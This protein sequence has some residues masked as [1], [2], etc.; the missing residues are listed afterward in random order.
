MLKGRRQAAIQG[1]FGALDSCK[2]LDYVQPWLSGMGLI[3]MFHRVVEPGAQV[4]DPTLA[5]DTESLDRILR[6]IRAR[7][8][9]LITVDELSERLING[10]KTRPFVCCTF[11]DGY[12]DNKTLALPIFRRYS[13]PFCVNVTVG[14]VNRTA[15]AWWDALGVMLQTQDEIKF[16]DFGKI[17]RLKVATWDEKLAAYRQFRVI[18]HREVDQGRI[19]F[20]ESWELNGI[21]LA[22]STD[23]LFMSW[24]ELE[25]LAKDPL[26]RI[27]SHTLTHPCLPHLSENEAG[28]EIERSKQ[29]LEERLG[30]QVAHLAYPFGKCGQREFRLVKELRFKTAVTSKWCNV[31]PAHRSHQSSLP[32]KFLLYNDA[33]EATM[34]ACLYGEDLPIKPW[35]RVALD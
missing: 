9:D 26:V 6:Y 34:R 16:Y 17:Q 19:P 5:V 28:D 1:F 14:Y 18:F 3:L 33:S 12:A 25:E 10:S 8:W 4:F 22:A 21:N 24:P 2:L 31:F 32:R 30:V 13:A 35:E 23:G 29:I 11:D 20:E 27:G 15:P 7:G